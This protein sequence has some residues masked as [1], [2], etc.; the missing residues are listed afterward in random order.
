MIDR[1]AAERSAFFKKFSNGAEDV[2][3]QVGISK[4]AM[5]YLVIV[6][7]IAILC[8]VYGYQLRKGRS[9]GGQ[10]PNT[11][12]TGSTA[13]TA[14][15]AETGATAAAAKEKK[16]ADGAEKDSEKKKTDKKESDQKETEEKE[17]GHNTDSK[18]SN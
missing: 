8:V 10:E 6:V 12:V 7:L 15:E 5:V 13:E 4:K 16:A 11:A 17:S 3:E 1:E 18:E 9:G 2:R 14:G